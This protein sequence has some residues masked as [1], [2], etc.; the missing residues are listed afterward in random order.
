MKIAAI[1]PA[2]STLTIGPASFNACTI[3]QAALA[4]RSAAKARPAGT[5][6]SRGTR[7]VIKDQDVLVMG[8]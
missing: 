4:P 5:A 8:N 2:F 6:A 7:N 1:L 3:A